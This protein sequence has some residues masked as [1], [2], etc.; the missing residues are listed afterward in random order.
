MSNDNPIVQV[1]MAAVQMVEP[2]LSDPMLLVVPSLLVVV[3]PPDGAAVA[4]VWMPL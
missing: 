1:G 2:Q 4:M 3:L